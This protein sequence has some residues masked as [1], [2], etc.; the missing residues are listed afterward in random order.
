M[1]RTRRSSPRARSVSFRLTPDEHRDLAG[2][3]SDVG[4]SPGEY[5]RLATLQRVQDRQ[6][7]FIEEEI[8][9]IRDDH[10]KL[11]DDLATVCRAILVALDVPKDEVEQFVRGALLG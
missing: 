3:A 7:Q 6:H 8:A 4:L 10:A 11:R 9:A 2:R 5:A 1:N